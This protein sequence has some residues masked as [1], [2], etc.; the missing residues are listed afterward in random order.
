MRKL[1]VGIQLLVFGIAAWWMHK[2][3]RPEANQQLVLAATIDDARMFREALAS[4]ASVDARDY[5]GM[6]ALMWAASDGDEAMV[7]ELL[8]IGAAVSARSN[9]H[10]TALRYA[11]MHGKVGAVKMLLAAGAQVDERGYLDITALHSAAAMPSLE[12]A[13][14]LLAH[15]ADVDARNSSGQTPLMFA[16]VRNEC[17]DG[18]IQLLIESGADLYAVDNDQNTALDCANKENA[19]DVA[20]ILRSI[21]PA[22]AMSQSLNK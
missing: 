15:G 9:N 18:M 8:A 11:A 2:P 10:E 3:F 16:A 17:S 13:Q 19:V 7:R 20:R 22:T 21:A 12:V 14:V 4:G 6:T 5:W 1:L